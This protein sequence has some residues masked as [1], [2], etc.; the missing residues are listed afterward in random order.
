MVFFR[1]TRLMF[2]EKI[3]K[4]VL[5]NNMLLKVLKKNSRLSKDNRRN[6]ERIFV[7]S[8][9]YYTVTIV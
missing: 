8:T 3:T 7:A 6:R 1:A 9:K 2:R 4:Q 5:K